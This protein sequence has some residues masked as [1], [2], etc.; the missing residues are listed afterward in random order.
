MKFAGSETRAPGQ[1]CLGGQGSPKGP[2]EV[3]VEGAPRL[4]LGPSQARPRRC[5]FGCLGMGG[6]RLAR[7][8][9]QGLR[10]L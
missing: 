2:A 5:Q 4:G 6:V 8:V 10:P 1:D 3:D 9:P 7:I